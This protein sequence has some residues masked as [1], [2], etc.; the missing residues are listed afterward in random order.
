[1]GG[2]R[3]GTHRLWGTSCPGHLFQVP[4][5]SYCGRGRRLAGSSAQPQVLQIELG[6]ADL[7]IDQ[8]GNECPETGTY[9]LVGS[10]IGHAIWVKEMGPDAAYEEGVVCIP[11]QGGPQADGEAT[12]ERTGRSMD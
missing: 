4:G 5:A 11:P 10:A 1:M 2:D 12:M 7:D 8:E 9:L 6:A 3:D